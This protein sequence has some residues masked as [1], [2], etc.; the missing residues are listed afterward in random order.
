QETIMA[1]DFFSSI[2]T[3]FEV[4]KVPDHLAHFTL[5]QQRIFNL[6]AKNGITLSGKPLGLVHFKRK[7][8]LDLGE[9]KH[10]V[11]QYYTK[12]LPFL[13]IQDVTISSKVNIQSLP[14][15]FTMIMKRQAYKNYKGTVK[16]ITDKT[17][18]FFNYKIQATLSQ[19][20]AAITLPRKT[21][22]RDS[23]TRLSVQPFKS[24]HQPLIGF[25]DL[26]KVRTR[27]YIKAGKAIYQRDVELLPLVKKGSIVNVKV[28]E[29]NILINFTATAQNDGALNQIITIKRSDGTRRKAKVVD[30]H[31]VI[32]E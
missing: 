31:K 8:D 32:L 2:T 11:K 4:I 21:V 28:I 18:Y 9:L 12:K 26:G 13:T 7:S 25:N 17:R 30:F 16:I 14:K 23:N 24:Y 3:D 6:F 19:F 27:K 20:K 10:R 5:A 29:G 22:L 15:K 1:S